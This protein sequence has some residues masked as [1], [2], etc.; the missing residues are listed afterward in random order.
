MSRRDEVEAGIR[1]FID[2]AEDK[3]DARVGMLLTGA[4]SEHGDLTRQVQKQ[5]EEIASLKRKM[6]YLERRARS[7]MHALVDV[8]TLERED[9]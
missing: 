5:R 6:A 8:F 7:R 9:E 2:R 1:R 4:F 3:D